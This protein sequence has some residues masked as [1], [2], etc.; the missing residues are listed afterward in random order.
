MMRPLCGSLLALLVIQSSAFAQAMAP[1]EGPE[2]IEI[3]VW[4]GS[5]LGAAVAPWQERVCLEAEPSGEAAEPASPPGW[6]V[7]DLEEIATLVLASPEVVPLEQRS[8]VDPEQP[9]VIASNP[10]RLLSRG[11]RL[12]GHGPCSSARRQRKQTSSFFI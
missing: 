8:S 10:G 11:A 1:C 6:G 5:S 9:L 2:T 7:P 12:V 4:R 3:R